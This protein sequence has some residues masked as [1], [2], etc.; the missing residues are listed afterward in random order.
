MRPK[1]WNAQKKVIRTSDGGGQSEK[2]RVDI[3][4]VNAGSSPHS[5]HM[6]EL[7]A[8]GRKQQCANRG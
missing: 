5:D 3:N 1:A 8:Y 7:T 6:C 2:R 4:I